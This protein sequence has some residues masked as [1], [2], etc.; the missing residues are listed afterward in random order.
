[1]EVIKGARI[2]PVVATPAMSVAHAVDLMVKE[3]VGA[4]VVVDPLNHVLGIFTERDNLIRI[5]HKGIDPRTTPLS[6]VMTA[7]VETIPAHHSVEEALE[8]MIRHHF[9]HLPV[10]DT[11]GKLIAIVSVRYLL[12]RRISEKQHSLDVLEA[13]VTAG[14][15]G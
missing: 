11:M 2:P 3:N 14:G 9:R 12:M 8:R 5:T 1:M 7:P 4:V 10:V 15:P 6:H 13:Y